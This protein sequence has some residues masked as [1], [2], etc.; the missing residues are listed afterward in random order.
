MF[1]REDHEFGLG[2]MV[3]EVSFIVEPP[4]EVRDGQGS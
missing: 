1:E 2:H 4:R 3:S